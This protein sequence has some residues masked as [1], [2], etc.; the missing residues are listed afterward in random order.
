MKP[1]I[2]ITTWLRPLPTYLGMETQLYT[3][4]REYV[5]RVVAAGGLPLLLSHAGDAEE[6]LDQLD[7][8][9]L[10]GGDDIH[11]ESYGERHDGTS[12]A[13]NRATDDWEIALVRAAAARRLPTLGICR[14]MQIMAVAF[15]GKLAQDVGG[16]A[17]H[18][19]L[20]GMEPDAILAL[21]HAVTL[22]P[23][24]SLALLY[25]ETNHPVNSL[26]HQAVTAAGTLHVVGYGEGNV[27]EA[28]ETQNNWPALGV[29]WHPEKM[30]DPLEDRLF[31]QL[32]AAST[33]YARRNL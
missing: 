28:L 25:G 4:A 10:S 29:Q 9:L 8:L 6:M 21:R 11:P 17:G 19:R 20:A 3:L 23:S 32:V 7:G 13:V 18:P 1:R 15:G 22:E 12:I 31:A 30:P 24:C 26:H 16:M 33:Q 2:G 14:G 27:I 5:D